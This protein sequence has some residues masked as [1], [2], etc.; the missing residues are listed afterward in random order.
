MSDDQPLLIRR[1]LRR[2]PKMSPVGLR[3]PRSCRLPSLRIGLH[4][5]HI[6]SRV[7]FHRPILS[8]QD[9]ELSV[10]NAPPLRDSDDRIVVVAP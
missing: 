3:K 4:R 9:P 6:Y 8:A 10:C 5:T 2:A 1:S 7:H